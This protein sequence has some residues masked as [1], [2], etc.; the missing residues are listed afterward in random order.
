[1]NT[2]T[3]LPIKI[4]T[5]CNV[6]DGIVNKQAIERIAKDILEMQVSRNKNPVIIFFRSACFRNA[7]NGLRRK[8]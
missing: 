3:I 8:T 5:N 7:G 1:M 2:K 6:K 4:G